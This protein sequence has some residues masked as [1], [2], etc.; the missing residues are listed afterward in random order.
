[1]R[2]ARLLVC[3][4]GAAALTCG[5]GPPGG[6]SSLTDPEI[7]SVSAG[8]G[9]AS[10]TSG[11]EASSTS[12][13]A[14]SSTSEG[15][16]SSASGTEAASAST[17]MV[18]DLGTDID[19]GSGKPPGCD[20]KIDFL[21]VMQ[22]TAQ[23]PQ[24]QD[25]LIAAFPAFI[26]TIEE[27]FA[28]FDVHIMVTDTEWQWGLK[29]CEE[30]GCPNTGN[31]GCVF[32]N[33]YAIPDYPCG[34]Y[35]EIMKDPCNITLGA[36][37]IFNAGDG[38]SN[39]PCAIDDDRRYIT[40]DQTDL[41]GTFA[42]MARVGQSGGNRVGRSAVEAVSPE[43]N[44]DG[45]CN[46]GF[47][48]DDALLMITWVAT[49]GDP[50]SEGTPQEWA[51]EIFAAKHGNKDSVIMLGIGGVADSP[52][53]EPLLQFLAEFPLSL[54]TYITAPSYGPGFAA[55]VTLIDTACEGF[56]PPG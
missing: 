42:C 30:V 53:S 39:V 15:G 54:R 20:D 3:L 5:G 7:T 52:P 40:R 35:P 51:E 31:N 14:A 46:A 10:S 29:A 16:A 36:G 25:K 11:G 9:E 21:F 32:D 45:G 56:V 41:K 47:L 6:F 1:M 17:T 12:G 43:L 26:D 38:A 33:D 22:R 34:V 50:Y 37:V 28:G 27:R 24:T 48:R 55:A 13:G 49:E 4:S 2:P 23:L 8:T 19:V 44:A 18:Y